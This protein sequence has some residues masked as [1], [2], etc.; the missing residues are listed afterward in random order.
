MSDKN[1]KE[2]F[3]IPRRLRMIRWEEMSDKTS[4]EWQKCKRK[5]ILVEANWQKV[6]G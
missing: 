1:V 4:Y 2:K 5:S 6:E 3:M